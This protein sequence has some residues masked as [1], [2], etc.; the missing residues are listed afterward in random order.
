MRAALITR[1]GEPVADNVKLV[2]DHPDPMPG[3]G[4]V[5]V[6]TEAA[7]LNQ[8][9]LWVGRGVPG[10]ELSYPRIS[11]SDGCGKVTAVGSAVDEAWIGRRVIVNAAVPQPQ[12]PRP[13]VTPTLAPYRV[14]GE[15]DHGFMAEFGVAPVANTLAVPDDADPVDAAAFGLVHL[16]AWRMMVTRGRLR[17]GRTVLVTGIGGGVALA[18]LNI[19]RHFGC[20]VIVTSRHESKLERALALGADAAVLDT[21]A[22]WSREVR[23]HTGKRGVDMCVDSV[24]KAVHAS[25]IRSLAQGGTLVTCGCTSGPDATTDLA[26]LFWLQLS[27]VGSTMGDMDEFR[28]VVAL[29]NAG[30]MKPTIDSVHPADDVKKAYARLESGEQ[31]GKV[32]VRWR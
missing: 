22:D 32:V 23:G 24:G 30:H 3:P 4:E 7:A 10:A 11:G 18:A 19:C 15:H 29:F 6:R 20:R 16:T 14:I 27:I 28:Q 2:E 9:D 13:G 1:V 21:G 31:F 26:R 12:A 5:L 25:C 8:L 17:H